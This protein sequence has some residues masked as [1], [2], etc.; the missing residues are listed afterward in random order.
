MGEIKENLRDWEKYCEKA[1]KMRNELDRTHSGLSKSGDILENTML[2]TL[3]AKDIHESTKRSLKIA[4]YSLTLSILA[5]ATAIVV[6]V[7]LRWY[8]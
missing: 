1:R 3:I 4:K 7:I 5:I 8:Y 2:L 6:P